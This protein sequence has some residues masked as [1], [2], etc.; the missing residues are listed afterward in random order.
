MELQP[1]L[2]D[3]CV[4]ETI[5]K[6]KV[7]DDR[8]LF[9]P[10]LKQEFNVEVGADG[11]TPV[12]P[13]SDVEQIMLENE[14]LRNTLYTEQC[15]LSNHIS[16]MLIFYS[17]S[18]TGE[19]KR[20]VS[21]I[22]TNHNIPEKDLYKLIFNMLPADDDLVTLQDYW[23]EGFLPIISIYIQFVQYVLST[24]NPREVKIMME[25]VKLK[26]NNTNGMPF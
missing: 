8:V 20:S 10:T 16:R 1:K 17:K 19:I 25:N 12:I 9:H 2:E 22:S 11:I 5:V 13:A 26:I 18:S 6:D 24:L 7:Y 15:T 3:N 4:N 14:E 23:R 21:S